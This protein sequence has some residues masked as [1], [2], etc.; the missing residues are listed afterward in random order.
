[1][2]FRQLEIN[3]FMFENS[4]TVS[5]LYLKISM[6]IAVMCTGIVTYFPLFC[7]CLYIFHNNGDCMF[8]R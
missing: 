4:V 1:M 6:S 5:C 2:L 7:L 3:S 8:D